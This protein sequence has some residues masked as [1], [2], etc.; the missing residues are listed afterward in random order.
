METL[1]RLP[2]NEDVASFCLPKKQ[3]KMVEVEE[4]Q[5]GRESRGE[6]LKRNRKKEKQDVGCAELL[7]GPTYRTE[8]PE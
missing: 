5:E 7:R 1:L 3:T 6:E 2:P 4:E 8:R